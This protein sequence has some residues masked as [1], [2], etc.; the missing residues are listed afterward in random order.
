[1][2]LQNN[3]NTT[4]ILSIIYVKHLVFVCFTFLWP[5][6]LFLLVPFFF[7]P[8]FVFIKRMS[9]GFCCDYSWNT[10]KSVSK[11]SKYFS[12][13]SRNSYSIHCLMYFQTTSCSLEQ[14]TVINLKSFVASVIR[15]TK[16]GPSVAQKFGVKDRFIYAMFK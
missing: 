5:C 2:D 12:R 11:N 4:S 7:E 13:R 16:H 1:M 10:S 3:G 9:P 8:I 6:K 14:C 15:C